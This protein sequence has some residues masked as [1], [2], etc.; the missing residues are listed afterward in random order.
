MKSCLNCLNIENCRL[1]F[2][3]RDP[4]IETCNYAKEGCIRYKTDG[5]IGTDKD[6][7]LLLLKKYKEIDLELIHEKAKLE[8][9]TKNDRQ[10]V[11]NAI[12]RL[13]KQGYKINK[14]SVKRGSGQIIYSL[15]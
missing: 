7:I 12:N 1:R 6:K 13:I 14:F 3:I 4:N 9:A 11:W 15:E 10:I 2:L 5:L 8:I